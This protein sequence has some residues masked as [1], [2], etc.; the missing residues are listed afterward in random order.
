MKFRKKPVVVEAIRWD[1]QLDRIGRFMGGTAT[2]SMT[3]HAVLIDTPE[4]QMKA[5]I[6]DWIIRGVKGEFYRCTVSSS[7]CSEFWSPFALPGSRVGCRDSAGSPNR[8]L[9]LSAHS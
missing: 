1:G 5:R 3:D 2:V 4:G 6:G 8:S 9:L 7:L